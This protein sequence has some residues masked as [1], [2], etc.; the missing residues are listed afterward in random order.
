M[1][2]AMSLLVRLAAAEAARLLAMDVCMSEEESVEPQDA[3][4]VMP[5][6]PR[7]KYTGRD[8]GMRRA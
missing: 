7:S 3:E 8:T 6:A 4:K 5:P 2:T 1:V